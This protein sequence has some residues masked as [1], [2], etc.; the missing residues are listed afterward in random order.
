MLLRLPDLERPVDQRL[1]EH[2]DFLVADAARLQPVADHGDEL[3]FL[4]DV[5]AEAAIEVDRAIGEALQ[6]ALEPRCLVAA[7][8]GATAAAAIVVDELRR[9]RGDLGRIEP[10]K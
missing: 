10:A 4:E 2:V 9:E 3:G 7:R 5:E 1:D 6:P 8:G